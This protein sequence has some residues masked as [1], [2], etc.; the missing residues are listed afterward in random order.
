VL[1]ATGGVVESTATRVCL[2]ISSILVA[3]APIGASV[4]VARVSL[5]DIL[6]G[7]AIATNFESS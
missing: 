2:E 5:D 7:D 6:V 3:T 4:D 1:A